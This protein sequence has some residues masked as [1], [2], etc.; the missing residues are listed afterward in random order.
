MAFDDIWNKAIEEYGYIDLIFSTE[1]EL[2]KLLETAVKEKWTNNR[3]R[4]SFSGTEWFR[5]N[6]SSIQARGFYQR[7]YDELV[8]AG[9][10][11]SGT[12]YA[13]GLDTAKAELE[14]KLTDRGIS[15][16]TTQLDSWAK[17]LYNSGNEKNTAYVDRWLNTRISFTPGK[18]KGDVAT[19]AATLR[20][21]ANAQGFNF[22]TDFGTAK[23]TSWM[24]RLDKGESTEAIKRE[25]E[26]QAMIGQ[27]ES[28]KTLM[29]QGMTLKDVYTPYTNLFA[30]KLGKSNVNW[31]DPWISQNILSDKGELITNWEF[32]KK[33]T[34]HPDYEFGEEANDL[35][36]K[37]ILEIKRNMGLEG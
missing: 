13:R 4:N 3:F 23:V 32:D 35:V 1:P 9:K 11:A 30:K 17:E 2:R 28:V 25:I 29:K 33:L 5:K 34:R 7:Q 6:A 12:E 21:Y 15:Y 14:K 36:Y 31:R 26:M 37:N 8:K 18:E 10:D 22:D 27:P 24:Q 16:D 19:Y 20:D